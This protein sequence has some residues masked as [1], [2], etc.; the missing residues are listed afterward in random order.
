[1]FIYSSPPWWAIHSPSSRRPSRFTLDCSFRSRWPF[2]SPCRGRPMQCTLRFFFTSFLS[3]QRP[4]NAVHSA[5]LLYFFP[6]HLHVAAVGHGPHHFVLDG[7]DD[8]DDLSP[9]SSQRPPECSALCKSGCSAASQVT[10]PSTA[11]RILYVKIFIGLTILSFAKRSNKV[12]NVLS[13]NDCAIG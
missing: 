13:K 4:P 5:I 11:N 6:L 3:L 10:H 8:L 9:F 1:M 2:S 12:Q 7:L